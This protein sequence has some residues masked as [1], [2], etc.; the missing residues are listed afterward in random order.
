MILK[1]LFIILF[2][3]LGRFTAPE[4]LPTTRFSGIFVR[5]VGVAKTNL[6]VV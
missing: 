1:Y 2:V 5:E 6:V 3:H 4:Q